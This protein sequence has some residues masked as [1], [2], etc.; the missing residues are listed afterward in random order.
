M[1]T[2][3]MV[4][5]LCTSKVFVMNIKDGEKGNVWCQRVKYE[6]T[7][8]SCEFEGKCKLLPF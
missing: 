6:Y 3:A 5:V 1:K 4:V 2:V 7:W 8:T